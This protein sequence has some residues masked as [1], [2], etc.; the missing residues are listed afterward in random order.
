MTNDRTPHLWFAG[1]EP[2][3]HSL[4][5]PITTNADRGAPGYGEF[6]LEHR[7]EGDTLVMLLTREGAGGTTEPVTVS[8]AIPAG[9][10]RGLLDRVAEPAERDGL[11]GGAA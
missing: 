1:T 8:V 7:R 11:A 2:R 3:A 5:V 10:V 9:L 6:A 4:I